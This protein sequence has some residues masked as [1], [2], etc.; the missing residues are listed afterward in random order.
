MPKYKKCPRCELNYILESEDYCSVCKDELKG[1]VVNDL[2]YD[3]SFSRICPRCGVNTITDDQEY[4][5]SCRADIEALSVETDTEEEWQ[6]SA[7]ETEVAFPDI[8]DEADEEE[9]DSALVLEDPDILAE[10]E[11]EEEAD[12]ELDKEDEDF[13]AEDDFDDFDDFGD[14]DDYEEDEEEEE[15]EEDL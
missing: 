10:L 2:D 7:K 4:C 8:D 12:A 13:E 11:S 1:I 3:D 6:K 9:L 14:V 15:S 5:E